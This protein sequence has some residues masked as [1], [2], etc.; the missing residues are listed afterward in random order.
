MMRTRGGWGKMCLEGGW[1]KEAE[2][3]ERSAVAMGG[4]VG[5]WGGVERKRGCGKRG[6]GAV[7]NVCTYVCG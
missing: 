5:F 7:D 6:D 3:G 1:R 4:M 2:E